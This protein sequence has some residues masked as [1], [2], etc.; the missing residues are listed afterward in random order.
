MPGLPETVT[1][2]YFYRGYESYNAPHH[3]PGEPLKPGVIM[4]R[5][6]INCASQKIGTLV[7]NLG[8]HTFFPLKEIQNFQVFR[9]VTPGLHGAITNMQVMANI[10]KSENGQTLVGCS[11]VR[12]NTIV[13]SCNL[14][15]TG[16]KAISRKCRAESQVT[17]SGTEIWHAGFQAMPQEMILE[18]M[19]QNA[20]QIT[21]FSPLAPGK[22]F[23]FR[24]ADNVQY[25]SKVMPGDTLTLEASLTWTDPGRYGTAHCLAR[26]NN[27]KVA[28][29]TINFSV[30]S[31]PK[32][33][34]K[35][36]S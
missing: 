19:A 10:Q 22:I 8:D 26:V 9:R 28:R 34:I 15:F 23:A 20:V 2:L 32:P 24:S 33:L 12:G 35:T 13:A 21:Q 16:T 27:R 31:K 6:M 1:G 17:Y 36:E 4:L 3:F 18:S 30:I 29:A 14:V 5:E 7:K 25:F 11:I